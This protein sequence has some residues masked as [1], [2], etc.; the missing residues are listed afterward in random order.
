ML[1]RL[2]ITEYLHRT[3]HD[4]MLL[5]SEFCQNVSYLEVHGVILDVVI[6]E[7][8]QHCLSGL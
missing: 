1:Y 4:P 8:G 7:C 3:K 6:K 2:V 5:P